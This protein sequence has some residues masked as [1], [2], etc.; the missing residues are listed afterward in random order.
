MESN[1]QIP[2]SETST[3]SPETQQTDSFSPDDI[4]ALRNE[5]KG[6][7]VLI[8]LD[9]VDKIDQW[10]I[11][12]GIARRAALALLSKPFDELRKKY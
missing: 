10:L 7:P 11:N 9:E 8:E 6:S 4:E 2:A 12:T 1:N 3:L 5:Y